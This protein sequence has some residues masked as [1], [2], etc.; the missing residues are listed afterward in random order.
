MQ[1]VLDGVEW[2]TRYFRVFS[3]DSSKIH[4]SKIDFAIM[5]HIRPKEGYPDSAIGQLCGTM[6]KPTILFEVEL[7]KGK[8][9]LGLC[10]S[11]F[12]GRNETVASTNNVTLTKR[13]V[14]L[15]KAW[16]GKHPNRTMSWMAELRKSHIQNHPFPNLPPY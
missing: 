14:S 8:R 9:I 15:N 10:T 3:L 5:C 7:P 4:N 16:H 2:C 6:S 13:C 12:G 11:R 1:V